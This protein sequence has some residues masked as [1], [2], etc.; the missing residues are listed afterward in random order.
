MCGRMLLLVMLLLLAGCA[1]VPFRER[2]LRARGGALSAVV[3]HGEA[4]LYVGAPG[5]WQFSR[6]FLAPD[7]YAWKIVTAADP[8]WFMF[9]GIA[10]RSF[11]GTDEVS[12]DASPDAALRT[13]ARW[14]AVIN[15]DALGQPGTTVTPLSAE[16]LPPEAREGVLVTFP[17]A[18]AYR[19]A[20][21]ERGLVV[22]ARGPLDLSPFGKGEV[23]ARFH[24]HRRT[25][26]FVLPFAISYWLGSTP[27][28]DEQILAACVDPSGL[29]RASFAHPTHLPDC[30]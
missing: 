16:E 8:L 5:T 13:Q 12:I 20:V 15:L 27:I 2:A 10:V 18:A 19:L 3:T 9:D 7:C 24:D 17:D 30:P 22:W 11:I 29:T 23:T 21:D 6:S 28:V 26:S 14:T 25:G 1:P 4:R